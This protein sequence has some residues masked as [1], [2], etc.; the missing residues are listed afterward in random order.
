MSPGKFVIDTSRGNSNV[1]F[2]SKPVVGNPRLARPPFVNQLEGFSDAPAFLLYMSSL[3][4]RVRM[5]LLRM[6]MM[7]SSLMMLLVGAV[8]LGN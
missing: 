7:P 8:E 2:H 6:E 4:L 3:S 5:L 1:N